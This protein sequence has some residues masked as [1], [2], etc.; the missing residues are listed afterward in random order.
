MN[1]ASADVRDYSHYVL[2]DD[3]TV[4]LNSNDE[5]A[6]RLSMDK[7]VRAEWE[8]ELPLTVRIKK[9][10]F[11]V[12]IARAMFKNV[13]ANQPRKA[14]LRHIS[15]G[16]SFSEKEFTPQRFE[17]VGD[18]TMALFD[19][20]PAAPPQELYL[21]TIDHTN[22]RYA[23]VDLSSYANALLSEI[24]VG[25]RNNM[26]LSTFWINILMA[27]PDII[28]GK[29]NYR[30]GPTD[31]SLICSKGLDALSVTTPKTG[32]YWFSPRVPSA[33]V[34]SRH[35][36]D[37]LVMS[38][39]LAHALYFDSS[40]SQTSAYSPTSSSVYGKVTRSSDGRKFYTFGSKDRFSRLILF[41]KKTVRE[42]S[43]PDAGLSISH[44]VD[45]NGNMK[46]SITAG[47]RVVLESVDGKEY[48]FNDSDTLYQG[49]LKDYLENLQLSVLKADYISRDV[50]SVDV[51][52]SGVDYL[53]EIHTT[54]TGEKNNFLAF[55]I[56]A[57]ESLVYYSPLVENRIYRVLDAVDVRELVVRLTDS[58][59]HARFPAFHVGVSQVVLHFRQIW[60]NFFRL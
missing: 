13:Q 47:C 43:T 54:L 28:N 58:L 56:P 30:D 52:I 45:A 22:S 55:N 20:F 42:D 4:D 44:D 41:S 18:V 15:S 6:K 19:M 34:L 14:S 16:V 29:A 46:V 25:A 57:S 40:Q 53:S 50:S 17:T 49:Q 38:E 60:Q 12:A 35:N 39:K 10:E 2:D 27:A 3:F 8:L 26:T 24:I 9:Q 31:I 21:V 59:D 7:S 5:K 11:E 48:L 32:V 1:L 37:Y 23:Y 51:Q 33:G 36:T